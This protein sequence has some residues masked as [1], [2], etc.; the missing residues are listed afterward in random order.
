MKWTRVIALRNWSYQC[1]LP[2]HSQSWRS[3][4]GTCPK[5]SAFSASS[6]GA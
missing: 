5:K 6:C 1:R 4:D 2:V 3:T